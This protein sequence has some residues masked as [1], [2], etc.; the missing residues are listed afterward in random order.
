MTCR[1]STTQTGDNA[2]YDSIFPQWYYMVIPYIITISWVCSGERIV[3]EPGTHYVFTSISVWTLR[4]CFSWLH[5][6]TNARCPIGVGTGL[7]GDFMNINNTSHV[8][9]SIPNLII[10]VHVRTNYLRWAMRNR[11]PE[12]IVKHA[13]IWNKINEDYMRWGLRI[14]DPRRIPV[15]SS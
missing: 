4:M 10:L 11:D 6:L 5:K 1:S 7:M 9:G 15:C 14:A 2:S 12:K 13:L 8:F 3:H